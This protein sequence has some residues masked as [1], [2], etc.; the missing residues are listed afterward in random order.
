MLQARQR[1]EHNLRQGYLFKLNE[2]LAEVQIASGPPTPTV[3][4]TRSSRR[5]GGQPDD[6]R[7]AK[8][9]VPLEMDT[10]Y[11]LMASPQWISQDSLLPTDPQFLAAG[12]QALAD[13]P[14]PPLPGAGTRKI[15]A[16]THSSLSTI[17]DS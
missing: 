9:E 16:A 2:T 8:M 1:L 3:T 13:H 5:P 7:S 6:S 4:S 12:H 14:L 15:P 11:R 17:S 10:V